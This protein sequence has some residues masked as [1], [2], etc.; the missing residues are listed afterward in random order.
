MLRNLKN[1]KESLE[2]EAKT[3]SILITVQK[4]V[5]PAEKRTIKTPYRHP[6]Y[7][8]HFDQR[9]GQNHHK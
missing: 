2:K 9:Q 7:K 1:D 6:N 4:K 8:I 5:N 3:N